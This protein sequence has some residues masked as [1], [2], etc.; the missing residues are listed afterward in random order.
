MY[1][2][3]ILD[4]IDFLL[5]LFL[6]LYRKIKLKIKVTLVIFLIYILSITLLVYLGP[7]G[8]GLIWLSGASLIAALLLGLLA[9]V[10]TI[11]INIA[12]IV[13]LALAIHFGGL[14]TMFFE[15][16]SVMAWVAVSL[17]LVI[18]NSITSI[19]L[20]LLLRALEESIKSERVLKL[21]LIQNNLQLEKD[22]EK[23]QESDQLKSA[24]LANLSHEIR[25]PMNSIVGFSELLNMEHPADSHTGRYSNQIF[26]NSIYLLNLI[27]DIVDISLI[28][29]GQI[30]YNYKHTNISQLFAETEA[31][32]STIPQLK[33]NNNLLIEYLIAPEIDQK[34][35]FT[36]P[37]RLKQSLINLTTNAIKYTPKGKIEI[38]AE[39]HPLGLKIMIKDTGVGI[40]ESEQMKIFGR[41]SKIERNNKAVKVQGIGLG[42]SITKALI[43]AMGGKI[44]FESK[45][46]Q[47]TTF[48]I[49]L[50]A[51]Y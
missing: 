44:W 27:N 34:S 20:A 2:L 19:P 25:T 14:N 22:K 46:N 30:K 39:A 6:L 31:V 37:V 21:Q 45:E 33:N 3:A 24:F 38:I 7:F 13:V 36:D 23:A 17:N 47:G 9:S 12:I 28:E 41:F 26:Q 40:P 5:V 42:L 49:L 43:E 48:H 35:I 10:I 18:F 4:V 16:Y 50:P 1:F 32:V 51:N 11:G 15:S 8:P 29:S